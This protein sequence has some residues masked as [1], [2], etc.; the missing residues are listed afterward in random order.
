MANSEW[1]MEVWQLGRKLTKMVDQHSKK[2]PDEEKFGLSS[3]IRR[4]AVSMSAEYVTEL[5]AQ[6]A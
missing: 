6:S 4:A 2:F 3:E 5:P 1:R